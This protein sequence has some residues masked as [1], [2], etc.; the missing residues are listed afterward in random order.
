MRDAQPMANSWLEKTGITGVALVVERGGES[1]TLRLDPE[2]LRNLPQV[3]KWW[4]QLQIG[5]SWKE[6][7]PK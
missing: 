7:R 1:F 6:S 2:S 3:L 4:I 5:S